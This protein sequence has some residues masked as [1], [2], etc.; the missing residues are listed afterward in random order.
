MMTVHDIARVA[1]EVNRSYC[2][3]LGDDSQAPWDQAPEWQ[4]V[5]A[6]KGV[7]FH[8]A[9]AGTDDSHKEWLREKEA[10]GWCWGPDKRPDLKQHPCFMAYDLLPTEQKAKD[11]L[12]R[13]VVHALRSYV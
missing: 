9:N 4:R 8:L 5:S 7:M 6:V 12:F 3:A 2:Q 10:E 11:F 13:G 1:H